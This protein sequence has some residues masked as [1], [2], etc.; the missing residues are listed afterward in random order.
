V[1]GRRES[2]PALALTAVCA[3][4][5]AALPAGIGAGATGQATNLRGQQA[6][7]E[8]RSRA[9][10]LGL[11]SLDTQ[12]ARARAQ[13]AS[14][15]ARAAAVERQRAEAAAEIAVAR[16]V[17]H[18][19]QAQL[20]SRLRTLY[21]EGEPDAI[22]VLLGATS[23]QEAVSRLDELERSAHLNR[24]AIDESSA[25]RKHLAALAADLRARAADLQTLAAAAERTTTSLEAARAERVRYIARL[26]A[27]QRLKAAQVA[28]VAAAASAGARRAE[29]IETAQSSPAATAAAAPT[30]PA[31]AAPTGNSITVTATGYALG[32][33][34]STGLPV[35]WGVVAVDPSEIGRASCRERV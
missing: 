27:E 32:G 18:E 14:L 35:G 24:E 1:L 3:F 15:R 9:A 5:V 19:S 7:L 20:A 31:P 23:L 25:A 29:A 26:Q 21:E 10:V 6:S 17:L 22:A 2:R 4:L 34:T 28:R 33:T 11:Y 8:S 16:G 12:L 13:L 30:A